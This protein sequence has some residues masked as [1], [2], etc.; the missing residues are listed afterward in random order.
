MFSLLILAGTVALGYKLGVDAG[1][2]RQDGKSD[3]DILMRMPGLAAEHISNAVC[4]TYGAVRDFVTGKE[5]KKPEER[6]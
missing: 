1:K 4:M 3:G 2:L 6:A 5:Q